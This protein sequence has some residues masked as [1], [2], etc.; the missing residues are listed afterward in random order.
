MKWVHSIW[1]HRNKCSIIQVSNKTEGHDMEMTKT[2]SKPNIRKL[3]DY[4]NSQANPLLFAE[5]LF[6]LASKP[7]FED[8]ADAKEELQIRV[9]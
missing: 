8:L 4:I 9:G 7:R 1:R 2:T 6:S 5:A 3:T